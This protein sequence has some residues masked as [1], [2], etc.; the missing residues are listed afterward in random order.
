MNNYNDIV[1]REKAPKEGY[2]Y[3]S[4]LK[5]QL[6]KDLQRKLLRELVDKSE[7]PETVLREYK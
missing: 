6:L 1:F 3:F 4:F 7:H 5:K 2:N